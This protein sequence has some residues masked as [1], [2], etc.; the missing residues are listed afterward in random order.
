MGVDPDS[1]EN[2]E[3]QQRRE[4][5]EIRGSLV[6]GTVTMTRTRPVAPPACLETPAALSRRLSTKAGLASRAEEAAS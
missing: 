1:R 6:I 4:L 5:E 2:L 3:G